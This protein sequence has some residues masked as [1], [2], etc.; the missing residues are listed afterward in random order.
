MK[1]T[2]ELTGFAELVLE[3]AVELGIARSKTDALRIGIFEL[4]DKYKLVESVEA[5]LVAR[6]IE[7]IEEEIASGKRKTESLEDVLKKYPHLR[8]AKE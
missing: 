6:K 8:S 1:T 5:E 3:K 2:V 4:N 7:R